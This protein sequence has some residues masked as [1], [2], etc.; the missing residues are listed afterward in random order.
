MKTPSRWAR[1]STLPWILI[2]PLALLLVLGLVLAP[3]KAFAASTWR[4][5]T[6]VVQESKK[7]KPQVD[8]QDP[9]FDPKGSWHVRIYI[10][11][12]KKPGMN[13]IPMKLIFAREVDYQRNVYEPGKPAKDEPTKLQYPMTTTFPI[14]PGFSD[15]MGNIFNKTK[16]EFDLK[17]DAGWFIAGEY[18]V[19]LEGP[20]GAIGTTQKLTLKGINKR[21]Y[22]GTMNFSAPQKGADAGA[23]KVAKKDDDPGPA[24]TSTDVTPIGT[25]AP[26]VPESAGQAT[27]EEKI[28]ERPKGCGCAVPG[29]SNALTFGAPFASIAALVVFGARR[30]KSKK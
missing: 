3:R 6:P 12:A 18:T 2:A 5:E 26:M 7:D 27:D 10:E 11:L 23:P 29:A 25:G 4:I 17:R 13:T 1:R 15:P 19:K 20:D 16:F 14:D 9:D 8:D 22:R 24:P 21:E 30:R 28:K